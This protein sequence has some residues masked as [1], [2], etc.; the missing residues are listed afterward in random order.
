VGI[1]SATTSID[2]AKSK[3]LML[4][5]GH[6]CWKHPLFEALA[7]GRLS[8]DKAGRLLRNYDAHASVLRRLL[9]KAAACMPEPA[10][11]FVLENV[12]NEYGN[13]DYARNHQG[14]LQD[15]A[16]SAGVD[17][18][19]YE[20]VHIE[21]G[22]RVFCRRAPRFYLAQGVR[23]ADVIDGNDT[24]FSSTYGVKEAAGTGF[25][26]ARG[27]NESAGRNMLRAAISAGAITGTEILAI[28]EFQYLQKAFATIGLA[29][30][31][32]FNHVTIEAEHCDE[33]LA[34]ALY[35]IEKHNALASV[36]YGMTG[37]LDANISL[38]DGLLSA[39]NH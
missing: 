2:A 30:H 13:G 6:D 38:Y 3:L 36:E 12:R 9:L 39:L 1:G 37:I 16:W 20:Q 34:L 4:A 5:S 19:F 17:R 24:G 8:A 26:S 14:Q 27:A 33:S 29:D 15:V 21:P 11:G 28:R 23:L 10:V 7:T 25:S 31:I 22:V 18:A 35:F 32:W